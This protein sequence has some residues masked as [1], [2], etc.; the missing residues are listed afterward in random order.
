M[1]RSFGGLWLTTA[2]SIKISPPEI[3]SS[4]AIIR[5]AVDLPQPEGPTRTMNSW[6]AISRSRPSITETLPY[7]FCSLLSVTLAKGLSFQPFQGS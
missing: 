6:S 3:S 7:D 1:S 2:P 4:P 5:S